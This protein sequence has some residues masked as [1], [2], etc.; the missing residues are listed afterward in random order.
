MIMKEKV[1]FFHP[2]F[3]NGGVERTN[4]R[5]GRY[6][7]K[8]GYD[9]V[10]LS[11]FFEGKIQ[12]EAKK[13]GIELVSLECKRTLL[14]FDKI[15][16]YICEQKRECFVHLICCQNF[17]NIITY[18]AL[19]K[20]RSN[21]QLIFAERNDPIYLQTSNK[22]KDKIILLGIKTIYKK[23]DKITA[24]SIELAEDL[25]KVANC[26]VECIYNPTYSDVFEKLSNQ[27]VE[28]RWFN[29]SIPIVLAVGRLEEQK[30][31][32]M[33][34]DAFSLVRKEKEC[35]LVIIGEGSQR[36]MLIEKVRRLKLESCVKFLDFDINPY[37]YMAKADVFAVTSKYEGLCNTLIEATAVKTPC[38][39][40]ECKSGNKE[41]LMNGRGGKLSPEGDT[42]TFAESILWVL[43]NSD[44]AKN[45]MEVAYDNLYRFEES[46]VGEK[47][48]DLLKGTL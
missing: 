22:L 43:N 4:I 8:A 7:K 15:R 19:F 28:D 12:N 39:A 42:R 16:S 26:R 13:A 34:I 3:R 1:I 5:V 31:Y 32:S 30:N 11:L 14:A 33:L 27:R 37:K 20:Q 29:E 36:G 25:S 45:M 18:F 23:A 24:N 44:E 21:L 41:I 6:L 17:A 10:F 2:Y 48:I 38:V 47:Y 46:R 9:V 35:R 40:T